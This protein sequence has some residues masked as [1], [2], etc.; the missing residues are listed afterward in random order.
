M[1]TANTKYTYALGKKAITTYHT[2]WDSTSNHS[3][4]TVIDLSADAD[5]SNTN[6]IRI[7]RVYMECTAGID[8]K[9]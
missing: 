4:V 5:S 9:L 2:L 3:G 8:A 1:A 6:S 7:D